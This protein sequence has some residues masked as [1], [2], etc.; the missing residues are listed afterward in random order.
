MGWAAVQGGR[1][2]KNTA[3]AI[4]VVRE[5]FCV[6][7]VTID[8]Q[9]HACDKTDRRTHIGTHTKNHGASG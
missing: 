4:L 3:P 8:T 9:T 5:L 7:T 6:L 1:C 2:S